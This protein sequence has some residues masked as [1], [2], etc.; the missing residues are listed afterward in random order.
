[1]PG[2]KSPVPPITN[3]ES[4]ALGKDAGHNVERYGGTEA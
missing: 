3:F 2:L 4:D 1:M